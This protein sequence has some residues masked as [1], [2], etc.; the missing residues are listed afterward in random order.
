MINRKYMNYIKKELKKE[1]ELVIGYQPSDE[2]KEHLKN[3]GITTKIITKEQIGLFSGYP[4][5]YTY[6]KYTKN[7][8]E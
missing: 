8:I 1:D 6:C 2:E 5:T 4:V 7:N 3:Y